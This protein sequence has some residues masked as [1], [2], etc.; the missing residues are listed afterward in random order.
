MSLLHV[1][2]EQLVAMK[3]H[4]ALASVSLAGARLTAIR[5]SR[6][7]CPLG[8][9]GSLESSYCHGHERVTH[10]PVPGF[11]HLE[12]RRHIPL[13]TELDGPAASA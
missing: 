7:G 12:R 3:H 6:A 5:P 10:G 9:L 11:A 4:L 2:L 1:E 8:P 13:I